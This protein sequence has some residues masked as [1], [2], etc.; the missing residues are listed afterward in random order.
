VQHGVA[1]RLPKKDQRGCGAR[2]GGSCS[3]EESEEKSKEE[4]K[5]QSKEQSKEESKE[6]SKETHVEGADEARW[7]T[8]VARHP[9]QVVPAE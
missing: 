5:E 3:K 8:A 4:S 2:G 7:R 9:H 1:A 6:Q